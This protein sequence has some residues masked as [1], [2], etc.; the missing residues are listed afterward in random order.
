MEILFLLQAIPFEFF[1]TCKKIKIS[2]TKE[3]SLCLL[4]GSLMDIFFIFWNYKKGCLFN[5]LKY[6]LIENLLD[7]VIVIHKDCAFWI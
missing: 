7:M 2:D 6:L 1:S 3:G 5:L 4:S